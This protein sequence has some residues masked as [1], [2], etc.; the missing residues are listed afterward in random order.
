MGFLENRRLAKLTKE[1]KRNF[2]GLRADEV[3]AGSRE[4]QER[5]DRLGTDMYRLKESQT[6]A[7]DGDLNVN[8]FSGSV[9][10]NQDGSSYLIAK[11]RKGNTTKE[12]HRFYQHPEVMVEPQKYAH[13][14]VST[15]EGTKVTN[16]P[17]SIDGTYHGEPP[18]EPEQVAAVSAMIGRIEQEIARME[19]QVDLP[20][21]YEHTKVLQEMRR[22]QDAAQAVVIQ[23]ALDAEIA[24]QE[25]WELENAKPQLDA[26]VDAAEAAHD[27]DGSDQGI[28][29]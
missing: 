10:W 13:L 25:Q 8:V 27:I 4:L 21:S 17:L 9:M 7:M 22:R 12:Y 19:A 11:P 14:H 24:A 3:P 2:T 29:R 15:E 28:D 26:G 5:I 6:L 23:A 20:G 16:G 1:A 18:L